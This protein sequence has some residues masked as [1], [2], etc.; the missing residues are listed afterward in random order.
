[1]TL[2]TCIGCGNPLPEV[3]ADPRYPD[4]CPV[5][6]ARGAS[7]LPPPGAGAMP[8][9]PNVAGQPSSAFAPMITRTRV[10]DGLL[11]G[12]AAATLAGVAWWAVIS[13]TKAQFPYAAIAVGVLVGQ[14]VL[15]GARRG[16]IFPALVATVASVVALVVAEYFIQRSLAI[17]E[18]GVDL[19]LWLGLS[20]AT[21]I[22][23][24]TVEEDPLT[25]GF[26]AVA[27]I[28]AALSAGSR[29]RRPLL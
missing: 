3:A 22:V 2:T 13:T 21:D 18:L 10:I 8:G 1:M 17:A 11:L 19:P 27:A 6:M 12:L 16:G 7:M 28:V 14:A 4:R 20:S 23:R 5:C 29:N 26:W 24:G 15:I 25:G 9:W